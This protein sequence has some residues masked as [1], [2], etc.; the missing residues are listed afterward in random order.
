MKR[1]W[2]YVMLFALFGCANKYAF[3]PD[4]CGTYQGTLPAASGPGIETT[5]TFYRDN[6]YKAK[7]VYID[8][9]DGTFIERGTYDVEDGVIV[10][11]PEKDEVSYYK[12]DDAKPNQIYRLNMDKKPITGPLAQYYILRKTEACKWRM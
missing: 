7:L 8:E 11:R 9:K 5:I 3:V 12:V 10:V 1:L 2:M 4:C 6:T